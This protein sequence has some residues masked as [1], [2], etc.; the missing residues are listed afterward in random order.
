MVAKKKSKVIVNNG[1]SSLI[2]IKTNQTEKIKGIL[3]KEKVPYEIYSSETNLKA[4]SSSKSRNVKELINSLD[5][6]RIKSKKEFFETNP[7]EAGHIMAFEKKFTLTERKIIKKM[8]DLRDKYAIL[9]VEEYQL[10]NYYEEQQRIIEKNT[11]M[12]IIDQ[13][14]MDLMTREGPKECRER[15]YPHQ[16]FRQE[17]GENEGKDEGFTLILPKDKIMFTLRTFLDEENIIGE[18]ELELKSI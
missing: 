17:Y 8:Y 6:A 13:S 4:K 11:L 15:H 7:H 18:M 12:E 16:H 9:L 3:E 2:L 5:R 1:T 14:N 10:V